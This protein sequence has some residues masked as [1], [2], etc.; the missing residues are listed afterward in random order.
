MFQDIDALVNSAVTEVFGTML[1]MNLSCG[2]VADGDHRNGETHVAGAVGFI[3][4]IAGVVYIH[5]PEPFA[6]EIT[7]QLLGLSESEIEG[8]EMVNDAMGEM[9]NMI[10]G[11]MKSRFSDRGVP[12]VLTIP[13]VVRGCNFSIEAVST[14]ESRLY[15]YQYQKRRLIVELLVK[16]NPTQ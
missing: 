9:A 3:G 8:H 1:N 4:Q 7:G 12:C 15:A 14:T 2:S 5:V 13:S 16:N 6:K 11:H 10:V